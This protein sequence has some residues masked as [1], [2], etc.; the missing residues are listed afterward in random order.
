V[1]C[2]ANDVATC[3]AE[4]C[5]WAEDTRDRFRSQGRSRSVTAR[6]LSSE[7]LGQ[8]AVPE[9]VCRARENEMEQRSGLVP[10]LFY[11]NTAAMIDWYK[12]VFGFEEHSRIHQ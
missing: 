5:D 2:H 12:A 7:E 9:L 8:Y 3:Q 11:D 10:Y 6:S 4:R 1:P